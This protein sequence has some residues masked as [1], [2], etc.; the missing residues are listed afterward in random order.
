MGGIVQGIQ[1]ALFGGKP[2]RWTQGQWDTFC[3]NYSKMGKGVFSW[4]DFVPPT[5]LPGIGVK[6][7]GLSLKGLVSGGNR[8]R[9][10]GYVET[11]NQ[12]YAQRLTTQ[13]IY[14]TYSY[15]MTAIGY[16]YDQ[17]FTTALALHDKVFPR[18]RLD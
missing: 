6:A 5:N 10:A 8:G 14:D 17:V 18:M 16:T 3:D 4:T 13:E 2:N 12:C 7:I 9:F 1:D 11:L 15:N